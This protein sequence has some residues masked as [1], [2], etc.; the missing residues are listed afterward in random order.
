MEIKKNFCTNCGSK[1]ENQNFCPNCGMKLKNSE[2]G[3]NDKNNYNNQNIV[4]FTKNPKL[5]EQIIKKCPDPLKKTDA[6]KRKKVVLGTVFAGI[7]LSSMLFLP[8]AFDADSFIGMSILISILVVSILVLVLGL[9]LS[10][11]VAYSNEYGRNHQVCIRGNWLMVKK[12]REEMVQYGNAEDGF[13][14]IP[15]P[16]VY[17]VNLNNLSNTFKYNPTGVIT[18]TGNVMLL[19]TWKLSEYD[20]KVR[21][22]SS[23][24]ING[25][26]DL[27]KMSLTNE[28]T[29]FNCFSPDLYQY[30]IK[31]HNTHIEEANVFSTHCPNCGATVRI[32]NSGKCEYCNSTLISAKH[33]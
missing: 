4:Y 10:K 23:D 16:M 9:T 5:E 2:N 3:Q 7:V 20:S 13:S 17:L 1:I 8:F 19:D 25:Q 27:N 32:S 28:V 12:Y 30:L 26:F 14:F 33:H 24:I 29:V 21:E 22:A 18:I 6:L 11:S 15:I 31:N